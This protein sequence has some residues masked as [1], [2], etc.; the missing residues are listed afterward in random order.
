M[1]VLAN[2]APFIKT[3]TKKEIIKR[4]CLR[5]KFLNTKS[6]RSISGKGLLILINLN[7]L[8]KQCSL[9]SH[10]KYLLLSKL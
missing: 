9:A 6:D 8:K 3:E 7:K 2:Q 1:Y 4:S 10:Q 5:S